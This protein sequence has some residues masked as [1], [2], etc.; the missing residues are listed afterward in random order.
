MRP[1]EAEAP[2][3]GLMELKSEVL[4]KGFCTMCGACVHL[5]P[6]ILSYKGHI[7]LLDRCDLVQGLCYAVCPRSQVNLDR[8]SQ[9]VFGVPYSLSEL[10]TT[11]EITMARSTDT[12]IIAHAQNGGVVT[13][14]ISLALDES[15]VDS[16]VLN[17][18]DGEFASTP[19]LVKSSKEAVLCAGVSYIASPTLEVF[20]QAAKHDNVDSISV[21]STPC[22][23]L[24]LAKM[25]A[26]QLENRNNIDKLKLVIGLFCTWGLEYA[27]FIRFLSK[28][29][30]PA[31]V[32]KLD[33]PP[34]P[35]NV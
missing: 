15:I 28:R 2:K 25:R 8:A 9:A 21:V 10:G 27:G 1:T 19:R 29:V 35:A 20:N 12:K 11:Q 5:C 22:Q 14:L 26:S 4:D 17:C 3:K 33:I 30:G 23:V 34:P 6:Y 18:R 13:T 24:A 7:V 31:K 32:K 16:A